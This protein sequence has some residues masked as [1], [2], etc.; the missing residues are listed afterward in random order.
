MLIF[1]KIGWTLDINDCFNVAYIMHSLSHTHTSLAYEHRCKLTFILVTERA[2][3]TTH[4]P[5]LE[6]ASNSM[7]G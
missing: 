7:V 5:L 2:P 3:F 4:T 6:V 1:C